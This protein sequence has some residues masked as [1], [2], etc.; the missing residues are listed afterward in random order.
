[1]TE[2]QLQTVIRRHRRKL[3]PQ[4]AA[5]L[6]CLA[7]SPRQ[8]SAGEILRRV[9]N[10]CP[11]ISQATVYRTLEML[12]GLG[13]ACRVERG[14]GRQGY[15]VRRNDEHH[16]H[17]ICNGCNRVIDFLNCDLAPLEERLHR[18]TGFAPEGHMLELYGRCPDCQT[19]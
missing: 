6:A 7:Q 19:N 9:R 18:E 10:T 12:E 14:G 11:G 13:L 8:Q 2:K 15:L 4:R 3:T 1:M 16:H 5:V 17:L